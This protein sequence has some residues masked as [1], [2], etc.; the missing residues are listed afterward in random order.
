MSWAGCQN[1][2][3]SLYFHLHKSL[4]TFEKN[5]ADKI[6]SNKDIKVKVSCPVPNRKKTSAVMMYPNSNTA[7]RKSFSFPRCLL[8]NE[9]LVLAA[10]FEFL[11]VIAALVFSR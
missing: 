8:L 9:K 2:P 7:A 10:V 6:W 1:N 3:I 4:E 5:S 11:Y